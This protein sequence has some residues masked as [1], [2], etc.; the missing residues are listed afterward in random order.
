M[1]PEH[2]S[3][4]PSRPDETPPSQ[5][6]NQPD[7]GSNYEWFIRLDDQLRK[8]S[9]QM[10]SI[11]KDLAVIKDRTNDLPEIRT[12]MTEART[13]LRDLPHIETDVKRLTENFWKTYGI[14][15]T[16]AIVI[17]VV[18]VGIVAYIVQSALTSP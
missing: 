5:P 4:Q 8:Q 11:D 6:P 18:F 15:L 10:H 2:S 1:T 3:Q 14:M 17:Q 16:V 9:E 12:A 7:I 13:T